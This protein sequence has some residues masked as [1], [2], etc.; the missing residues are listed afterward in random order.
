MLQDVGGALTALPVGAGGAVTGTAEQIYDWWPGYA[1]G[2]L[3]VA[4]K[5]AGPVTVAMASRPDP[6]YGCWLNTS[7]TG[8]AAA[9]PVV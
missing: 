4:D 7:V 8:G 9:F 2:R 5:S 3:R 6:G 1:A